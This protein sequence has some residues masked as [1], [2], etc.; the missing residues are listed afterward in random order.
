MRAICDT[1]GFCQIYWW[2]SNLSSWNIYL[3]I[4]PT[5]MGQRSTLFS[6]LSTCE[7]I[8]DLGLMEI[9]S[10]HIRYG[11]FH[12]ATPKY[13][14]FTMEHPIYKWMI[15][16]GEPPLQETTISWRIFWDPGDPGDPG[17]RDPLIWLP[18][19]HRALRPQGAS[20]GFINSVWN[21]ALQPDCGAANVSAVDHRDPMVRSVGFKHLVFNT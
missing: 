19:R 18:Y 8:L 10:D 15:F 7:N 21:A 13:M 9:S 1:F 4:L 14:E 11:G 2:K 6:R 17:D 12:R 20:A 3:A 5:R 16:I